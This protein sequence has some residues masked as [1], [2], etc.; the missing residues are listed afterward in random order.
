MNSKLPVSLSAALLGVNGLA[1]AALTTSVG[2]V[3]FNG[4]AS[5]TATANSVLS[6]TN[7]NNNAAVATV[8]LGQFNASLGVLTGVDLTLNS[9][10][11]QS[12]EGVGTKGN[13][14][15]RTANG[16]GTSTAALTAPGI[17]STFTP[18]VTLTGAGCSL[19]SGPTGN[20]SCSWGPTTTAATATNG[21][22]SA[23]SANLNAYVGGGSVNA[24]LTLPSLSATSTLTTIAGFAS[25]STSTYTVGWSGNL[26]ATYTY[27]LHAAPSFDGSSSQAS[28]TLDFGTV[29]EGSSVA[30]LSFSLYNLADPDRIGLD[31]DS[32]SGTGDTAQLG[33]NLATFSGLGAG[34][35]VGFNATLDTLTV[36]LFNAQYILNLSDADLG[37]STTRSNYQLT[38]NLVGNVAPVPIPA[39]VWLFGSALAGLGVVGRK[40][41]T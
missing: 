3:S 25:S 20:I 14:P 8:G 35:S 37:A 34:S 31:L 23:N 12:I 4:S 15:G 36:G 10:R 29:L 11:T 27:L 5:V 19:A 6:A 39:A 18:A 22:S 9:S 16:S 40:K 2:P 7:S 38:L 30:P 1:H 17:S 24:S 28:L 33:T 41:A 32:F 21:T 13:G 26:A